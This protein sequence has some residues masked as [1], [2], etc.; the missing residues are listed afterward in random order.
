[1]ISEDS[2]FPIVLRQN[3]PIWYS[4]LVLLVLPGMGLVLLQDKHPLVAGVTFG[5][6]LLTWLQRCSYVG[7]LIFDSA[8][9]TEKTLLYTR[10]VL[11]ECT[12]NFHSG[13]DGRGHI[14]FLKW[15][16]V[17]NETCRSVSNANTFLFDLVSPQVIAY[18]E[19]Y[20]PEELAALMNSLRARALSSD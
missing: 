2:D 11:W 17:L 16:P 6:A 8:G 13:K 9:F 5:I 19:G 20:K 12:E 18:W 10:D 14:D 15:T 4:A 1:M 3:M 7:L